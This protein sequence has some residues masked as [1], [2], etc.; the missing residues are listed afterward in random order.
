MGART[1]QAICVLATITCLALSGR[2]LGQR[3]DDN[4]VTA[5]EDA[6]GTSV[7]FQSVG[8]YSP[9]DARGFN[10]QQAG[11]LRIEGL[12][13]DQQTAVTSDCL[14]RETTMRIGFAAQSYSF[15]A[16]TGI[17]DLGLRTPGDKDVVSAVLTRGVFDSATAD[18][19]AQIPLDTTFGVDLCAGYRRNF[20]IDTFREGHAALFG[21]TFRWRP[22]PR[23]EIIPFW[24][25]VTGGASR[26]VP[27]VYT[28]GIVT[29]LPLF[30]TRDLGTQGWTTWGWQMTTA[31]VVAK[32]ALGERWTL[33]VGLFHSH[34]RDPQSFNPY[35][36]LT[37]GRTA[38]S[39]M[40]LS[41]PFTNA[42]T[43]G[44]LRLARAF[45]DGVH[46]RQVQ[47]A[48]RGRTVERY[49]GGDAIT[50][51]GSILLDSQASLAQPTTPTTPLSHDSTRQLD[52]GLTYEERWQGVGSVA[53]GMLNDHYR[54]TVLIPQASVSADRVNPWLVNLRVEIERRR[55]L[56][57]YSSFV[58]GLEDSAVAPVSATNRYEPPPAT[59]TRQV[60]G[61][62]RWAPAE[63]V[64]VI[65]GAFDI[66]K[67]YFNV[68][69][70]NVY[71]QLGRLEYRG[72]EASLSYN[73]GG[74][75]VLAGGVRLQ[76][77]VERTLPEPGATG[78]TPL[79]PVPLTLMAS[80]DY[81][82]PRWGPWAASLQWNRLS[83]RV[84]TSDDAADLPVLATLAAGVRYHRTVG[85]Y[86]WTVRLDGFNL[87]DTRGLHVSNQEVLLPE[88]ARRFMLTIATDL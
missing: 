40:D 6:F 42:S 31:G 84:A 53:V 35:M 61:G 25:Y 63:D 55:D 77:R 32:S 83:S 70:G 72:L 29:P 49:F 8:L 36:T 69:A 26:I 5:A 46:R 54:R 17:V 20:A 7:G 4:A 30:R 86:A 33:A 24:S 47:L 10:P 2:A 39:V 57:F 51:L 14:V 16:P 87:T 28:D 78:D 88:P 13:F 62:V 75:T 19:E 38:D 27:I 11:N 23:T 60:D 21:T 65:F 76:P 18:L 79:G 48:I 64:R 22:T 56:V 3:A 37:G 73:R 74:L 81:A 80:V 71:T 82:P 44:E 50:D 15:P 34:E 59:R 1:Q 41:P 45:T 58:Q 9:N 66:H 68:D 43:S 67:P 85:S 12:Y 52:L